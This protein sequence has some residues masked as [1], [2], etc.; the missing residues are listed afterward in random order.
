MQGLPCVLKQWCVALMACVTTLAFAAESSNVEQAKHQQPLIYQ[1][2]QNAKQTVLE[3]NKDL[4]QLEKDLL[5]PPTV[6]AQLFVSQAPDLSMTL[7]DIAI[8]VDNVN[9][10]THLYSSEQRQALVQ[11][12]IQPLP[13]FALAAGLHELTLTLRGRIKDELITHTLTHSVRKRGQPLL[14]EIAIVS[15]NEQKQPVIEF[16]TW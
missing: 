7:S 1:T 12:A 10:I 16:R 3:L 14:V 9:P 8:E 13:E 11:G 2:I 4:Y 5:N 15:V 6:R